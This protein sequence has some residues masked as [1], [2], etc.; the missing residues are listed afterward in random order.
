MTCREVES[1]LSLYLDSALTGAQMQ[2]V[3]AHTGACTSCGAE[4]KQ[5]QSTQRLLSK[6][7]KRSAPPDLALRL[8]VALSQARA[9][10]FR[11]RWE[12]F[13]V[14][15][16]NG[17]NAFMFPATAGVLSAILFFGLIIG[18]FG[19]PAQAAPGTDVPLGL[20]TPPQL[21][22]S[23]PLFLNT[24]SSNNASGNNDE[25]ILVE[26]YVDAN[27]R[28][29]DYRIISAPEGSENLVPELDNLLI[30]TTFRPATSMGRP[31]AGH[32]VLSFARVNVKG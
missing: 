11:Q 8:R 21:A 4:L 15:L 28:V 19:L 20:F 25:P 5:L 2:Q 17:F 9:E 27:G 6:L 12:V 31:I 30:F 26:T 22:A 29:Q 10:S 3:A 14:R 7:G 23:P 18:F 13:W 24:I 16:E 32:V 1:L